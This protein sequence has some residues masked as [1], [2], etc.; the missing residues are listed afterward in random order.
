M[1]T[2]P[3][4]FPGFAMSLR[5]QRNGFNN[6]QFSQHGGGHL[7]RVRFHPSTDAL[8]AVTRVEVGKFN[9][10]HFASFAV[11]ARIC[12]HPFGL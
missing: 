11:S 8:R 2:L 7:R 6:P 12:N 5:S 10:V 1:E 9:F 4:H 3:R